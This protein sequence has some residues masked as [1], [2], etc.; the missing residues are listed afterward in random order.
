M[1]ARVEERWRG[2]IVYFGLSFHNSFTT[3]SLL[4]RFKPSIV[5]VPHDITAEV[6]VVDNG[7]VAAF[8]TQP[9]KDMK[10]YRI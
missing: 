1:C 7:M 8:T 6:D 4:A 9:E 3:K 2:L 10:T 5:T